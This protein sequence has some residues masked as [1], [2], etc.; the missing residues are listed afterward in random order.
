MRKVEALQGESEAVRGLSA[1]EVGVCL[2]VQRMIPLID[3]AALEVKAETEMIGVETERRI[4]FNPYYGQTKR[5]VILEYWRDSL[6]YI[7]TPW[8]HVIVE[9]LVTWCQG[10]EAT[11]S[12]LRE[13]LFSRMTVEEYV[14]LDDSQ[15][16][17]GVHY[18]WVKRVGGIELPQAA[19]RDD[20]APLGEIYNEAC[21]ALAALERL[22]LAPWQRRGDLA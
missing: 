8:G 6:N 5:G 20:D 4:G 19:L 9:G 21:V 11:L 1:E 12:R 7:L 17:R 18:Y 2:A 15:R 22:G 16:S 3:E 10:G 13:A 14:P